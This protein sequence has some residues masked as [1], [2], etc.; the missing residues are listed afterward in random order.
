[1]YYFIEFTEGKT[2]FKIVGDVTYSFNEGDYDNSDYQAYLEW[3][4]EG[5]EA[6]HYEQKP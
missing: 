4:S 5:N 2:I 6:I 1:M 3:V